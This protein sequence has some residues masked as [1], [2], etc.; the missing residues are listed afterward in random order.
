[1]GIGVP[2][3]GWFKLFEIL[4]AGKK[5]SKKILLLSPYDAISH[6]YW[7]QGLV[8][9]FP[10]HEFTVIV[11]PARY[12]S[13]RFRGNSLTLAYDERLQGEYDLLI[14]TSMTDLSALKGMCPRIANVPSVLYFH[15]NQF[16]YPVNTD[17]NS[18]K[19]VKNTGGL[20]QRTIEMQITNI[21]SALAADRLI[22]NS[23]YNK[24]TFLDGAEKLLRKMPDHVPACI[25]QSLETK[26]QVVPVPLGEECF[27]EAVRV[28][29]FSILWNHRWEFDK[30]LDELRQ[31]VS[32]LLESQVDFIFHLAG[33]QFKAVHPLMSEVIALLKNSNRLGNSGF[34]ES[35]EN[36]LELLASSH[37]VLSTSNHEFQGLAVQ[38]A[39]ASGCLPVVPDRLVYPEYIESPW[40]YRNPKHAVELLQ[41]LS[42][43]QL[44]NFD[45]SAL[46]GR[47]WAILR[48][49]WENIIEAQ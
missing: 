13:W 15:E 11:L 24:N 46:P 7:R 34:I 20:A 10:E 4:L 16:V 38:E 18:L 42:M 22:F 33:Q 43:G 28:G 23:A 8:A 25:G 3:A 44:Q 32:G 47:S 35:R 9:R 21:Y 49:L 19:A 6:Q 48:P 1:L 30:G 14:A 45:R 26:S 5:V 40:R 27:Q 31:I 39:I 2:L 29:K 12:F 17:S 36:Y 37:C 41:S